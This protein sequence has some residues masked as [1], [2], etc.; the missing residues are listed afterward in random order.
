MAG[1]SIRKS[2]RNDQRLRTKISRPYSVFWFIAILP[3][4]FTVDGFS[5]SYV[6]K[7]IN[8]LLLRAEPLGILQPW[9]QVKLQRSCAAAWSCVRGR[10][11]VRIIDVIAS[12]RMCCSDII[13]AAATWRGFDKRIMSLEES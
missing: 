9:N 3:N 8:A 7:Q 5:N 2:V 1:P 13:A 6:R 12:T 10:P 4:Y 11:G